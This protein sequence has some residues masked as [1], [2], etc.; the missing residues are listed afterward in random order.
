MNSYKYQLFLKIRTDRLDSKYI[1]GNFNAINMENAKRYIQDVLYPNIFN[2][3]DVWDYTYNE[4]FRKIEKPAQ[5]II[6]QYD[7]SL[8]L[9]EE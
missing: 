7:D 9:S 3:L 4:H 6:S 5:F 1:V 2:R 8:Y